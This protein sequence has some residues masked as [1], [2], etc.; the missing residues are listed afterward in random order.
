MDTFAKFIDISPNKAHI[1]TDERV[2]NP[3]LPMT[4]SRTTR[5]RHIALRFEPMRNTECTLV[6]GMR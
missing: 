3:P 5:A 1:P 6:T 2:S 4:S